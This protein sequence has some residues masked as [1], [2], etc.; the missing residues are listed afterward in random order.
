MVD[1][2]PARC[3]RRV[4]WSFCARL[5]STAS[6]SGMTGAGVTSGTG[7]GSCDG[8]TMVGIFGFSSFFNAPMASPSVVLFHV[9]VAKGDLRVLPEGSALLLPLHG[10]LS[11]VERV[12]NRV[13]LAG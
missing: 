7:I 10:L 11:C 6:L 5:I 1:A 8:M 2:L 4:V 3:I 13:R 9:A 12:H